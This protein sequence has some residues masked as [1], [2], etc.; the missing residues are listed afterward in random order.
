MTNGCTIEADG[1]WEKK[2]TLYS[3]T[4]TH[5]DAPAHMIKASKTL[6]QLSIDHFYGK[7]VLIDVSSIMNP[8]IEV[9]D[10]ALHEEILMQNE[11]LLIHTG[12][13]HRWGTHDYFSGYP[14]LSMEAAKWLNHLNLKG[15]GVDAISVDEINS[16][17][18][19]IHNILLKN[20]T[21][22]IENLKN[23]DLIPVIPF[24][25]SCFPL[26]FEEADGSP[27]RAVALF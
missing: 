20:D 14:V 11:F 26:K 6:D 13:S 24:I 3:H 12:W 15:I 22:I 9:E 4:G 16:N 21:V 25:F 7:A 19:L 23:L 10:L 2:M 8:I 1:F 27:V 18:F 5:M 17:R